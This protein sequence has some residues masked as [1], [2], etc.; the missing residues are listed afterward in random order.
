[1]PQFRGFRDLFSI[2]F[3]LCSLLFSVFRDVSFS[4]KNQP[5][6]QQELSQPPYHRHHQVLQYRIIQHSP[7]QN[8]LQLQAKLQ[9]IRL[10]QPS[11]AVP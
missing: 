1:M 8:P 9:F 3:F 4:I 2:N 6:F 7:Q 11:Q 5:T 10:Q